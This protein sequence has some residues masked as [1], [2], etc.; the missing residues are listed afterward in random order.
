MNITIIVSERCTSVGDAMRDLDNKAVIKGDFIL[1][2]ASTVSNL[3]LTDVLEY[4]R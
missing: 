1:L 2:S 3:K 4:H